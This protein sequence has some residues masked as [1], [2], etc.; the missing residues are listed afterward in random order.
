MSHFASAQNIGVVIFSSLVFAAAVEVTHLDQR[1]ALNALRMVGSSND[2]LMFGFMFITMLLSMWIPNT[3]ATSIVCPIVMTVVDHMRETAASARKGRTHVSGFVRSEQGLDEDTT[4]RVRKLMLLAVAYSSNIGGTGSL[5]GTPPNMVLSTLMEKHFPTA[6]EPTFVS[7]MVYNVPIMF[8]LLIVAWLYMRFLLQEALGSAATVSEEN[9]ERIMREI[10]KR[11]DEL[12]HITFSESVVTFLMTLMV[13]LMFS[14][15]PHF[16][17]GWSD[18]FPYSSMIRSSVPMVVM[19]MLLFIIPRETN[20]IGQAEQAIITWEDVCNHVNWGIV[21]LI[22]GGMTIADASKKSG[23]TDM[24]VVGMEA[25]DAVPDTVVVMLL[26][27][28]SSVMTEFTSNAAISKFMLPVVLETAMHRRVHPLY[29][30]IPTTI[31]CSFA[32]M[33]PASTPPNAI[34]YHLG[35][36]TPGDMIG[37]GFLMNL[38][39][40]M[41]EIAAIHT[42]GSLVFDV[43]QFPEWASSDMARG[44]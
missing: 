32:F 30:G 9:A 15:K 8:G 6:R 28:T 7:W 40:V 4:K 39:C 31:G 33:L 22:C 37:P 23:L 3:A 13:L 42:I 10:V 11:C 2:R 25:L 43:Y 21:L 27:I 24:M 1:V 38:I 41:F 34:V 29:F 14:Q 16:M 26:C 17:P 20:M 19:L 36:M 5:I 18:I 35:R 44:F 12:G